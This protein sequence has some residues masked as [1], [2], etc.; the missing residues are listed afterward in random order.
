MPPVADK[1]RG[2]VSDGFLSRFRECPVHDFP[3]DIRRIGENRKAIFRPSAQ[4][5]FALLPKML[6][7]FVEL[8][9]EF[10]APPIPNK[11]RARLGP[12][13]IW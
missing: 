4:Q 12:F 7:H 8:R 3:K 5:R 1:R 10:F 13:L 9:F 11:K 2:E 6:T